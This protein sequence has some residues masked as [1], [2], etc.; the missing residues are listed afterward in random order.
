MPYVL[1]IRYVY[2]FAYLKS[3]FVYPEHSEENQ[4]G[5]EGGADRLQ[6]PGVRFKGILPPH[7]VHAFPSLDFPVSRQGLARSCGVT[8]L[9][10]SIVSV[11]P[12]DFLS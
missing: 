11:I 7:P 3:L 10:Q 6:G 1:V 8:S 5:N 9:S 12:E 4:G 2:L